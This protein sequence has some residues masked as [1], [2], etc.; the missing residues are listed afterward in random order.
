MA[1]TTAANKKANAGG[2]NFPVSKKMGG[3]SSFKYSP[4]PGPS[5]PSAAAGAKAIS[6]GMPACTTGSTSKMVSHMNGST[7]CLDMNPAQKR[8]YNK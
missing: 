3:G 5:Q 4:E 2:G 1:S 7:Q 6:C 8:K